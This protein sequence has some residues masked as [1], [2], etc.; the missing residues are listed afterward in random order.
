MVFLLSSLTYAPLRVLRNA[1]A[2]FIMLTT[3]LVAEPLTLVALGDSLTAGYG[4]PAD[5]GF[6][7]QLQSW[8]TAQG[9]EATVI[10]AGVSGDTTAG[11]VSRLEWTLTP[12]V[13]A[14]IV[15]LGGNDLLRGIDPAASRANLDKIMQA[16]TDKGLP[17]LLIGMKAPGN[18]GP[19]Y[20]AAFDQMY[21]Q[22]SATYQTLL[23]D[24]FFAA[25]TDNSQDPLAAQPFMQPDGIHP[26][27]EGV[28]KIVAQLGPQV[29]DL[30]TL[31]R[32]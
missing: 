5:Q 13:D 26:N 28:A 6:V 10:N 29:R 15:T 22:L 20:K 27:A 1:A 8:L 11:G 17:V 19:E 9:E 21:P 16:A 30:L 12:D 32:D 18:Y 25:L 14:L 31:A 2:T 4:L 23:A 7:P 24:S 3:P